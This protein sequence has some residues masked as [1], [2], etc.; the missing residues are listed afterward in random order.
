MCE[1]PGKQALEHVQG[2]VNRAMENK[3]ALCPQRQ[4]KA[5]GIQEH[6]KTLC[7]DIYHEIT[8][9]GEDTSLFA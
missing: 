9:G 8:A 4:T 2:A 1:A 7:A 6:Q 3:K 5:P